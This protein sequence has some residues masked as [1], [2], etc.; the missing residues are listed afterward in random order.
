MLIGQGVGQTKRNRA[1]WLAVKIAKQEGHRKKL[2][3]CAA[4][5]DSFFP[6]LD[7]AKKLVKQRV[8]AIFATSTTNIKRDR[9]IMK[10]C[11][12]RGTTFYSL[13]DQEARM[14]FGH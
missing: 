5:S 12:A 8:G 4:V 10:Y 3:G 14:F 13:P 11:S 2:R 6:F 7:G 9:K 1:A